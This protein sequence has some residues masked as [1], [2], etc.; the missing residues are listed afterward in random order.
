MKRL[1]SEDFTVFQYRLPAKTSSDYAKTA[2]SVLTK[3]DIQILPYLLSSDTV[4][5]LSGV[6]AF[7]TYITFEGIDNSVVTE[8]QKTFAQHGFTLE[9]ESS[10]Y[11]DTVDF[12]YLVNHAAMQVLPAQYTFDG[13]FNPHPPYTVERMH[14]WTYHI[15]RTLFNLMADG[16]LPKEWLPYHLS[17]HHIR[18]GILLGYPGEA[19]ACECWMDV[20]GEKQM[21]NALTAPL[22][23]CDAYDAAWP[24]YDYTDDVKDN[25]HI[26]AHQ[27]LWSDILTEVYESDWHKELQNTDEFKSAAARV[28]RLKESYDARGA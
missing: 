11:E 4:L 27:K 17:A 3:F 23:Y 9:S 10:E 13:W 25:P 22:A 12:F 8:L 2:V 18:F 19:I 16:K 7:D 5:T 15:E 14:M 1:Q 21:P 24:A 28:H 6:R 26:L 20:L